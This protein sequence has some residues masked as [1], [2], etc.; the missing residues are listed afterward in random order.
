MG[1]YEEIELFRLTMTN[2]FSARVKAP[3]LRIYANDRV[4]KPIDCS[5][6]LIWLRFMDRRCA[7]NA[8]F[9]VFETIAIFLNKA[10]DFLRIVVLPGLDQFLY[11]S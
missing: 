11:Y 8:T 6:Q 9:Q 5:S 7:K 4:F 2:E 10:L 1:G 3:P